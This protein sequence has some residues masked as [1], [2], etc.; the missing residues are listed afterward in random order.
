MGSVAIV[1]VLILMTA[2]PDLDLDLRGVPADLRRISS[3]ASTG[4]QPAFSGAP[5][6]VGAL[7]L[8]YAGPLWTHRPRPQGTGSAVRDRQ[9]RHRPRARAASATRTS[10]ARGEKFFSPLGSEAPAPAA[11]EPAALQPTPPKKLKHGKRR[12]KRRNLTATERL[13]E[14]DRERENQRLARSLA[15]AAPAIDN[16]NEVSRAFQLKLER[17]SVRY[18]TGDRPQTPPGNRNPL[19]AVQARETAELP[20]VRASLELPAGP[21]SSVIRPDDERKEAEREQLHQQQ[22]EAAR[23]EAERVAAAKLERARER[24]E[25]RAA[26]K[27]VKKAREELERE[28]AKR[29]VLERSEERKQA[30]EERAV[31]R[32]EVEEERYYQAQALKATLQ[33]K[34]EVRGERLAEDRA[35]VLHRKAMGQEE[36]E[37]SLAAKAE[38]ERGTSSVSFQRSRNLC[39]DR[40]PLPMCA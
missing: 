22:V 12:V 25:Q 15:K 8:A 39:R 30:E 11:A 36:R 17:D 27:E 21:P 28:L 33:S 16:H 34:T 32:K 6:G 24:A 4:P 5:L 9:P 35:T 1:R 3:T 23:A 13:Q 18:T 7:W 29:R 40:S 2:G 14:A 38:A 19:D 10:P 20:D 31:R 37:R 26:A